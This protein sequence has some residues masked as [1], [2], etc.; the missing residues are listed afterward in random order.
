MIKIIVD[1]SLAYPT[2]IWTAVLCFMA[3]YWLLVAGGALDSKTL[4]TSEDVDQA[5][6]EADLERAR[7]TAEP[8]PVDSAASR[9]RGRLGLRNVPMAVIGTSVAFINYLGCYF[10]VRR[11]GPFGNL[12]GLALLVGV[13]LLSMPIAALLTRILRPLFGV[14]V[15]NGTTANKAT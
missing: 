3:L 13:L 12:G 7:S 8:V 9:I 11:K 10:A 2:A 4:G 5:K 15:S 1:G 14:T 6:R